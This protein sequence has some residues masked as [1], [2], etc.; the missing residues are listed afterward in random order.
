MLGTLANRP[1]L[2]LLLL[3]S[4]GEAPGQAPLAEEDGCHVNHPLLI[5]TL[6]GRAS[7]F[8][9]HQRYHQRYL[10]ISIGIRQAALVTILHLGIGEE[11][12]QSSSSCRPMPRNASHPKVEYL[13]WQNQP[14]CTRTSRRLG[15]NQ[16]HHPRQI[17]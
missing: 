6:P 1:N 11:S 10:K 16:N 2:S 4:G 8:E 7:T 14:L 9:W 5:A 17:Q 3:M 12:F 13:L 15:Y